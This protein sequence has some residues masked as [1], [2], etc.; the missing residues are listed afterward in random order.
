MSQITLADVLHW[1]MNTA[2]PIEVAMVQ[3]AL[4]PLIERDGVH[5]VKNRTAPK[6][7]QSKTTKAKAAPPPQAVS[8]SKGKQKAAKSNQP[9][10]SGSSTPDE[11]KATS[12][13]VDPPL[14]EV[15]GV[16]IL[17]RHAKDD[18]IVILVAR[19]RLD[20]NRNPLPDPPGFAWN[21]VPDSNQS[22]KD[23]LDKRDG[24]ETPW[25]KKWLE[26]Q[27]LQMKEL[28][29]DISEVGE[30]SNFLA[31][32]HRDYVSWLHSGT[33]DAPDPD[34]TPSRVVEVVLPIK[35]RKTYNLGK[36][37]GDRAL[38]AKSIRPFLPNGGKQDA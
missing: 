7:E 5:Q 22:F 9:S 12:H 15:D 11:E 1:A 30:F 29:G 16:G 13:S 10:G 33:A 32:C 31:R 26:I 17:A 35:G 2:T 3:R 21:T 37:E 6:S 20:G 8:D 28:S 19:T 18:K 27:R 4:E 34:T 23:Q 14:K 24:G 36:A 25:Q 38:R